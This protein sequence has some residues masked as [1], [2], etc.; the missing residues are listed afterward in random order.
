MVV[1]VFLLISAVLKLLSL[2]P[3][4]LYVYSFDW[5][6]MA[7][8]CYVSRLILTCEFLLGMMLIS[9]VKMRWAVIGAFALLF[10]FSAFL[11]YLILT[12]NDGNC[13]CLGSHFELKPLPSLG[14]NVVMMGLLSLAWKSSDWLKKYTKVLLPVYLLLSLILS[15]VLLAPYGFGPE[16]Q[17]KFS[18]EKYEELVEIH[19]D[20]KSEGKQVVALFSIHCKNCKSAMRKLEVA[21][22]RHHFPHDQVRWFVIG[23]KEYFDDFVKETEV[24]L[25]RYEFIH[26][27]LLLG[28][29]EGATPLILLIE[30]GEVRGRLSNGNFKEELIDDFC[31]SK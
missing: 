20:L 22:R 25:C 15:W 6:S 16:K 4:E 17:V 2:E 1:G 3:F 23:Q 27:K 14:K 21:L 29:T 18:A 19:P 26:P 13:H 8:S 30:N 5:F 31:Q 11:F 7:V 10:F 24:T 28:V 9:G 12:G